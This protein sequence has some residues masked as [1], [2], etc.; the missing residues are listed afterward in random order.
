MLLFLITVSFFSFTQSVFAAPTTGSSGSKGVSICTAVVDGKYLKVFRYSN[1]GNSGQPIMCLDGKVIHNS[2]TQDHSKKKSSIPTLNLKFK[3]NTDLSDFN[4][5]QLKG[6]TGVI[7]VKDSKTV[8]NVEEVVY[9]TGPNG[10]VTKKKSFGEKEFKCVQYY[11]TYEAS[12]SVVNLE[13]PSC[14]TD[15]KWSHGKIT[16]L[17]K[18]LAKGKAGVYT[19]ESMNVEPVSK[20]NQSPKNSNSP[21]I[22]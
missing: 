3:R 6:K 5:Y 11:G 17:K 12:Q 1:G 20:Q 4:F 14:I 21:A 10:R 9:N 13:K 2:I 7:Y 22:D 16:S 8:F 15:K 19:I 18:L